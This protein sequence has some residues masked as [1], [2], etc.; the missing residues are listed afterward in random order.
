MASVYS[1][2]MFAE[3]AKL[4]E[5]TSHPESSTARL[6]RAMF[7][8]RWQSTNLLPL[9]LLFLFSMQKLAQRLFRISPLLSLTLV[10]PRALALAWLLTQVLRLASLCQVLLLRYNGEWTLQALDSLGICTVSLGVLAA[11]EAGYSTFYAFKTVLAVFNW[12]KSIKPRIPS[13][14]KS[15][16]DDANVIADDEGKMHVC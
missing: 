7:S 13:M 15:S 14:K 16:W 2:H 4:G 11:I 8:W 5:A 6:G 3:S 9:L 12:V 10:L 1:L